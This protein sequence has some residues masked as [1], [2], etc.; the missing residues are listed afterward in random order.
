MC[1]TLIRCNFRFNSNRTSITNII[2]YYNEI[3][4]YVTVVYENFEK[5]INRVCKIFITYNISFLQVK[6]IY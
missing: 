2:R 6:K 4:R 3:I 1:Y 5:K